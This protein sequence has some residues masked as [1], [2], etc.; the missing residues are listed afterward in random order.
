[1]TQQRQDWPPA[2]AALLKKMVQ[3]GDDC[4]QITAKFAELGLSRTYKA[5]SRKIARERAHGAPGWHAQVQASAWERYN[6]PLTMTAARS[7]HFA[8]IHAP[9]HDAG[10]LNRVIDLAVRWGC[11]Q[12]GIMGDLID[13]A[14][15]CVYGQQA[16]V[17]FKEELRAT[18]QILTALK[19]AFPEGITCG[20]GNH[21]A[22][23]ERAVDYRADL[24]TLSGLWL[25]DKVHLSSYHWYKLETGGEVYQFEHP[26]NTS[27][28]ATLVPKRLCAKYQCH[29]VA[30]HGHGW[31]ISRD[32][33]GRYWA[34]DAG[35]CADPL[36]LAYAQVQHNVRPQMMQGAVIVR[37]GVPVLLSPNNLSFYEQIRW[38]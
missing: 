29:V 16:E 8:D 34:I 32:D 2:E 14:A 18:R 22:R 7:V 36:R 24:Q 15:F 19:S 4:A 20:M 1:M 37:D 38:A 13:M 12:G 23:I 21:E 9:F 26:R 5:I 10:F 31:G 3:D 33:S 28:H 11:T 35:I 25:D 6:Q 17:T 27:V 30:G